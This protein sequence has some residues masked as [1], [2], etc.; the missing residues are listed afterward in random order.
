[1]RALLCWLWGHRYGPAYQ[2]VR[3]GR[4]GG[5]VLIGRCERCRRQE[6]VA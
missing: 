5:R 4:G 6:R 3:A 1:M 2:V